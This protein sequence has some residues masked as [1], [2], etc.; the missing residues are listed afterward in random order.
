MHRYRNKYCTCLCMT[1]IEH[2]SPEEQQHFLLCDCGNYIDMRNLA[3]VFSHMHANLPEPQWSHSIKKD[4]PAIY[5]K[6]GGKID[7]N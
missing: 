3:E 2:F 1:S 5:L 6:S 7:L 4:E